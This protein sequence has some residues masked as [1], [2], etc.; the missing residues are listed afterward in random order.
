MCD[1]AAGRENTLLR[2]AGDGDALRAYLFHIFSYI[3][4][5]F[6]FFSNRIHLFTYKYKT[7]LNGLKIVE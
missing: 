1:A 5:I 3:F 6:Y 7:K 4:I 2:F